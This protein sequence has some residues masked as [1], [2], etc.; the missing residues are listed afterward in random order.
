M[1]CVRC[2][3]CCQETEM[4]LS[5]SDIGRIE[6]IG[7]DAKRFVRIDKTS[8]AKLRNTQKHCVFYNPAK[9]ECLIYDKRPEGCRIYP[10]VFDYSTG[11]AVDETCSERNSVSYQEQAETG[12]QVKSLL[13]RIDKEAQKRARKKSQ[14]A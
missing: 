14:K 12:L 1:H 6:R 5:E 13:A 2:G 3:L 11:I 7:Y 9:K 8:Y 4:L 10:V